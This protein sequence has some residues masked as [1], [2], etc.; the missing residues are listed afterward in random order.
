MGNK[1]NLF[2]SLLQLSTCHQPKPKEERPESSEREELVAMEASPPKMSSWASP[3]QPSEDLL[4][5]EESRGSA[6]WS[7]MRLE[8]F[9]GL[10]SRM[11]SEILSPTPSTPRERPSPPSMLST[12]SRDK[13]ELSTGSEAEYKDSKIGLTDLRSFRYVTIFVKFEFVKKF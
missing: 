12:R 3:S 1:L 4:A 11:W 5:E 7:T 2:T 8:Q 6:P 13:A 9:L 10:S